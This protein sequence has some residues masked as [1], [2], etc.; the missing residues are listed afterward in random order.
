MMKKIVLTTLGFVMTLAIGLNYESDTQHA[1]NK[2]EI[3]QFSHAD[4]F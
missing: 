2:E 4:H 1:L 3:Q